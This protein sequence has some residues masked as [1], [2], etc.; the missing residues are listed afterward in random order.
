MGQGP[1]QKEQINV[2]HI[3]QDQPV[4]EEKQ[5]WTGKVAGMFSWASL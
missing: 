3:I 1:N 4:E 5:S 2:L